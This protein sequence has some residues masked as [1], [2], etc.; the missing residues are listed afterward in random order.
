[1][2]MNDELL[3]TVPD[4]FLNVG[5]NHFSPSQDT[6]PLDYWYATYVMKDQEFRR[7]IKPNPNMNG[8]NAVQGDKQR[9]ITT[10]D[11]EVITIPGFG[12][13]GYLFEHFTKQQA[14]ESAIEYMQDYQKLY[15]DRDLEH[16]HEVI[17]RIPVSVTNLIKAFDSEKIFDQGDMTTE[18]YVEYQHD[19]IE[20]VT[21]G[22]TDLATPKY[23]YEVKTKWFKKGKVKKDGTQG[24]TSASIPKQPDFAHLM[25]VA[26]YWKATGLDT[27]IIYAT[28]NKEDDWIIYD[29][30]NCEAMEH[31]KLE[32]YIDYARRTQLVRQNLLKLSDNPGDIAKYIQPD[33]SSFYYNNLNKEQMKEITDLWNI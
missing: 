3:T 9:E 12:V 14:I 26:F 16:F 2:F 22:R 20:I 15:T 8:G 33:F 25:Q 27:K 4:Y 21:I 32:E 7:K 10:Q 29:K 31:H 13:G 23:I 19:D 11:G 5:L 28:G 6:K 18:T 24:F 17:K 30:D 1:M